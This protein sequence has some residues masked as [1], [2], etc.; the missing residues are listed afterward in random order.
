M[1]QNAT[2]VNGTKDFNLRNPLLLNFE[3]HSFGLKCNVLGSC[4]T[5]SA[6]CFNLE[7]NIAS[8]T[9]TLQVRVFRG[10]R[11]SALCY[12]YSRTIPP[13]KQ[14]TSQPASKPPS[15]QTRI[16]Q[17]TFANQDLPTDIG[18]LFGCFARKIDGPCLPGGLIID[19]GH[20]FPPKGHLCQPRYP[21]LPGSC[22]CSLVPGTESLSGSA[23]RPWPTAR[24]RRSWKRLVLSSSRGALSFWVAGRCWP[25]FTSRFLVFASSSSFYVCCVLFVCCFL[26]GGGLVHLFR[27]GLQT[28]CF[29]TIPRVV[30]F[31]VPRSMVGRS[32]ATQV[33]FL[34]H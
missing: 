3:P 17:P 29:A 6:L 4:G 24:T 31:Q 28:F 2:W 19:Q 34:C 12:I 15:Q 5:S 18:V 32:K 1:C 10:C 25:S 16:P 14:Q 11:F 9:D 33:R 21:N 30:T 26:R 8:H 23:G 13:A 22:L 7:S 20:L 27:R